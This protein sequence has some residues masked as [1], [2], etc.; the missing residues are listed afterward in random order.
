MI[1]SDDNSNAQKFRVDVVAI[2][3]GGAAGPGREAA[4]G[5]T[6]WS[7]AIVVVYLEHQRTA[8]AT[9]A[10]ILAAEGKVV[11]VRADLADELDVRRL[12]AESSASFGGVDVVVHT[13]RGR[14]S[15]F[16]QQAASHVRPSGAIISIPPADSVSPRIACQLRERGICVGRAPHGEVLSFLDTWR[17]QAG[18]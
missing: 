2:I 5:L 1:L 13:T 4:L 8:E 16:Y 17:Q 7:W 6:R 9:V 14:A 15:L 18:G 10:E 12:F 11:S 3:T